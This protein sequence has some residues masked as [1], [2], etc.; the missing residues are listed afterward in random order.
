MLFIASVCPRLKKGYHA[1]VTRVKEYLEIVKD[2][3]EL[4]SPWS[5]F[6]HFFGPE[7]SNHVQKN[8]ETVKKSKRTDV[9]SPSL[10]FIIFFISFFIVRNHHL[11]SPLG[12]TTRFNKAKLGQ[13]S[14]EE[15]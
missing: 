7:P 10:P 14:G 9:F 11:F 15:S 4:I 8:I 12:M 13:N 1:C 6:L 3:D 2:F 5:L